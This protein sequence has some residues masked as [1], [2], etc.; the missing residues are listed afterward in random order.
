MTCSNKSS[1]SELEVS[2]HD[3]RREREE[4]SDE[5]IEG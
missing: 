2:I 5:G 4:N 1:H 3:L